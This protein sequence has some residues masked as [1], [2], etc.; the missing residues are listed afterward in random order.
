HACATEN[1]DELFGS[2]EAQKLERMEGGGSDSID[3][4]VEFR[5]YIGSLVWRIG[6]LRPPMA[7]P[8]VSNMLAVVEMACL[9]AGSCLT[10]KGIRKS[11]RQWLEQQDG[12]HDSVAQNLLKAIASVPSRGCGDKIA[13]GS[14]GVDTHIFTLSYSSTVMR[15]LVRVLGE[16][17]VAKVAGL[18]ITAAES[19]PGNEGA[20][21]IGDLAQDYHDTTGRCR[22]EVIGDAAV[23]QRMGSVVRDVAGPKRV[24]VVVGADYVDPESGQFINKIGTACMLMAARLF[25]LP[26][27]VVTQ[28]C[29]VMPWSQLGQILCPSPT[30]APAR[31]QGEDAFGSGDDDDNAASVAT[32]PPGPDG[33]A[34]KDLDP[35][36]VMVEPNH[37]PREVFGAYSKQLRTMFEQE[38]IHTINQYFETVPAS[39]VHSADVLFVTEED[40]FGIKELC[41][42]QRQLYPNA[43]RM[44][45]D[46]T[47]W[48]DL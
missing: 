30:P 34:S 38:K 18:V 37:D 22:F 28:M 40:C 33:S 10:P 1:L 27:L 43:V 25:S 20:R 23:L 46:L 17:D 42:R 45:K 11:A 2:D 13:P 9:S 24:V 48:Q 16:P 32:E 15:G 47:A 6:R 12:S 7:A 14:D 41:D 39:V 26:V 29:K 19:R 44:V 8:I 4:G 31:G 3:I 36:M 5:N 35:H 21:L